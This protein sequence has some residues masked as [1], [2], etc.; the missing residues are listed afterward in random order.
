[1]VGDSGRLV[2]V[3]ASTTGVLLAG[4]STK[5]CLTRLSFKSLSLRKASS[6][7]ALKMFLVS[8]SLLRMWKI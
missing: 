5:V 2:Y 8:M 3:C 7:G 6:C 1:M 4:E